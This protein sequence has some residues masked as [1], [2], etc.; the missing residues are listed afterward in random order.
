MLK[1]FSS[2]LNKRSV[3]DALRCLHCLALGHVARNCSFPSKCRKC[4]PE[5]GNK[6]TTALH[7]SYGKTVSVDVRAA[8]ADP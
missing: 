2:E 3:I 1:R 4:E 7:E 6:H 8:E 5:A